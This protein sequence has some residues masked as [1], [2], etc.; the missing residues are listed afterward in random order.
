MHIDARNH[1]EES[2]IR[3]L[4]DTLCQDACLRVKDLGV[5]FAKSGNFLFPLSWRFFFNVVIQKDN[6][7]LGLTGFLNV[8]RPFGPLSQAFFARFDSFS[9]RDLVMH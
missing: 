4:N 5:N 7:L 9:C 8:A 2:S 3:R 6:I 1:P